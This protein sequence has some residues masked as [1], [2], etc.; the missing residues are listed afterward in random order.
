MIASKTVYV[1]L[2]GLGERIQGKRDI[3]KEDRQWV[4]PVS[5]HLKAGPGKEIPTACTRVYRNNNQGRGDEDSCKENIH[6]Q[7]KNLRVWDVFCAAI[8]A[9]GGVFDQLS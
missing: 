6:K 7:S 2:S 9:S 5:F 4:L 1:K 8:T 3:G